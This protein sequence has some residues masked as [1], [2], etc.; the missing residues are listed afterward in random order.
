MGQLGSIFDDGTP[1]SGA[2]KGPDLKVQ[3]TVHRGDLGGDDGVV[4]EVPDRVPFGEGTVPRRCEPSDPKGAVVLHLSPD[5]GKRAMLRLRGQGG[6]HPE[7]GSAGDLILDITVVEGRSPRSAAPSDGGSTRW[8]L[9]LV[10]L[11]GAAVAWGSH[12]TWWGG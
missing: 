10:V 6:K 11:V 12:G 1:T 4:V 3:A 9:L 5:S 8:P 7:T 2:V